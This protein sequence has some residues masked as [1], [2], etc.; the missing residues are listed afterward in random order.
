M[1]W[2]VSGFGNPIAGSVLQLVVIHMGLRHMGTEE[3]NANFFNY[4][5]K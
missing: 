5:W 1:L 4:F 2:D 3:G